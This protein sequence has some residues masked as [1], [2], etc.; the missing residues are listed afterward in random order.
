MLTVCVVELTTVLCGS[1]GVAGPRGLIRIRNAPEIP[2]SKPLITWNICPSLAKK[3]S[4][5]KIMA[6]KNIIRPDKR[7]RTGSRGSRLD[8]MDLF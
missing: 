5:T 6:V 1:S 3:C 2:V 8:G 7:I 4:A